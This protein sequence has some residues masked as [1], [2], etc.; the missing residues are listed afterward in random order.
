MQQLGLK[1]PQKPAPACPRTGRPCASW[2][3]CGPLTRC[4]M[5]SPS[6]GAAPPAEPPRPGIDAYRAWVAGLRAEDEVAIVWREGDVKLER[7]EWV[8]GPFVAVFYARYHREGSEVGFDVEHA[9]DYS[10]LEPITPELRHRAMFTELRQRIRLAFS[11]GGAAEE[12]TDDE[13]VAIAAIIGLE[14]SVSLP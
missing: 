9:P 1:T 7:V 14:M 4:R 10:R 12:L 3:T 11:Q 6:E 2:S 5:P 13:A 8:E